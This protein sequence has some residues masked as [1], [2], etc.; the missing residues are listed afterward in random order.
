MCKP[1]LSS[2]NFIPQEMRAYLRNYGYSFSKRACEYAVSLMEKKDQNGKVITFT[3][4]DKE[5]T[6]E[7]LNKQGVK[8]ENNIGYNHVYV[9]NMIMADRW[10]SSIE[11]DKHLARAVKDEIDDVDASPESIFRC[12][13]TK[14]EDKGIPI[15][16][17][18]II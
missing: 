11:D 2:Y 6:E 14:H 17:E 13:M 9:V 7:L 3:T 8:L 5:K 15:P 18:D 10:G 1:A 16:W 4:Y 12:W